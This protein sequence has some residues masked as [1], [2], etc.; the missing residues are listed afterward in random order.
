MKSIPK[1]SIRLF[2][3]RLV[4]E[5]KIQDRLPKND[6]RILSFLGNSEHEYLYRHSQSHGQSWINNKNTFE[7]KTCR[8]GI[9]AF[10]RI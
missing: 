6:A 9:S 8:M 10:A 4:K 3:D 5:E 2:A 1:P 7:A